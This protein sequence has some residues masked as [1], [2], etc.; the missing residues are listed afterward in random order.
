MRALPPTTVVVVAALLVGSAA[1]PGCGGGEGLPDDAVAQV[2]DTVIDRSD[3]QR[4]L[5]LA[6]G[7]DSDPGQREKLETGVVDYLIKAEWTRQEAEARGLTLTRAEVDAAIEQ[8]ERGGLL[9]EGTL[10]EAGVTERA[11]I[12]RLRQ[13]RLQAKLMDALAGEPADIP[14]AD[15]AAYYRRNR[16]ELRVPDRRDL[17]IVITRSG[18]RAREARAALEAG[19]GWP[20]VAREYSLHFSR[21]EGGRVENAERGSDRKVG[22]G[23]AIFT[24]KRGLLTGPVRDGETWAVFVVDGIEPSYQ[25]TLDQA[26]GQI[27]ELLASERTERALRAHSVKY[28][29]RTTCAPDYQAPSC[30]DG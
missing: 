12:E 16:P 30:G 23:A 1:F 6:A 5:R 22:L 7:P 8:A 19:Q 14:S 25:P 24:A 21:T 4:A 15:I 3:F 27:A 26:R 10:A 11:L 28:R 29:S 18:R 13:S 2:G 17:R 20:R 9:E